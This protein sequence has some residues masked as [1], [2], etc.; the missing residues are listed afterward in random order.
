MSEAAE[1]KTNG[2]LKNK[3]LIALV[4]V[5]TVLIVVGILTS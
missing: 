2:L 5:F 3:P 4:A 1:V